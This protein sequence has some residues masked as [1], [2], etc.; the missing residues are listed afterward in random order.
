MTTEDQARLRLIITHFATEVVTAI[1]CW[2]MEEEDSD[3]NVRFAWGSVLDAF[4]HCEAAM[5]E[6]GL[7]M[8]PDE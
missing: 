4:M 8:A 7:S 6:H 5:K 1:H 3:E 2:M